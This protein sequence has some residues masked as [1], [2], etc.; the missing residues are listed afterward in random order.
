M[1]WKRTQTTRK[2][3]Q[4]D[5]QLRSNRKRDVWR[6]IVRTCRQW[7]NK[8]NRLSLEPMCFGRWFTKLVF[9]YVLD[10]LFVKRR[11]N[12]LSPYIRDVEFSVDLRN[13]SG[14][15]VYSREYSEFLDDEEV[16]YETIIRKCINSKVPKY[17]DD[18]S[19]KCGPLSRLS[20]RYGSEWCLWFYL[21]KGRKEEWRRE[22]T[23]NI[24]SSLLKRGWLSPL[25]INYWLLEYS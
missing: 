1:T 8:L 3:H 17:H 25:L 10:V 6:S 20:F 9:F 11:F 12:T 23:F 16:S 24:N 7:R 15:N 19:G 5:S 2:S 13:K 4:K 18:Y 22:I 14:V 21:T